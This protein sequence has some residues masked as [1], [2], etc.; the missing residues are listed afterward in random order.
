MEENSNEK[1]DL[2]CTHWTSS[3]SHGATVLERVQCMALYS[4]D[5]VFS[6]CNVKKSKIISRTGS[7]HLVVKWFE[8]WQR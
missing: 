8:P 3:R 1:V 4:T 6:F 7:V 5:L 2:E